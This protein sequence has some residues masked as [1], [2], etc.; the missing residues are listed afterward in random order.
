MEAFTSE[1]ASVSAFSISRRFG[2]HLALLTVKIHGFS[3]ASRDAL[4][5]VIYLR[6]MTNFDDA[7]LSSLQNYASPL[8]NVQS[9]GSSSSPLFS[10]FSSPLDFAPRS[11][12]IM[13]RSTFGPI[14]LLRSRGSR[15]IPDGE[16]RQLFNSMSTEN[17]R[18]CLIF[19]F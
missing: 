16:V 13:R 12:S 9:R 2:T 18:S 4:T 1:L 11:I 14:S 19:S 10:S 15:D 8:L 7:S 6:A 5:V 17:F 3:E